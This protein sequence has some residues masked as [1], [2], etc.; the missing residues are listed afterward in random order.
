M[1]EKIF[2]E[3]ISN[4]RNEG[5]YREFVDLTR[6]AADFPYAINNNN[7][8]KILMWCINDY[9][10][11]SSNHQV[12]KAS[13]DAIEKSGIGSG[14]TRNIGGTNSHIV[15]LEKTISALHN[16]EQGL[17]FTSGY[18]AND[19]TLVALSK[20]MPEIVFFSDESNHASI[21]SGIKA[22]GA[23]KYVYNHVDMDS[24]EKGLKKYPLDRPKVI[25]FESVY[26]M[27]GLFS[28]MHEIVELAEKYNALTYV[29]EVHSV[30]MYGKSGAGL[31][32]EFGV[33]NKID[34]IQGTFAKAY[35]TIGGYITGNSDLVDAIRLTAPSFIFTTS[36]PPSIAAAAA[37][38]VKYLQYSDKERIRHQ[39]R[40]ATLK[41]A[42]DKAGIKYYKNY[43]H[44]V[45]IMV[46]DPVLVS[47]ISEKLLRE[48]K[49]YVQHINF[50]TVPKGTERLRITITPAHTDEMIHNLVTA[51]SQVFA[52][53]NLK[54]EEAA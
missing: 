40:V 27:D 44:I 2:E 7:G 36:L 47:K 39:D 42:L 13:K 20:I 10:G 29:D 52:E 51:I 53:V 43:S 50:P 23:E 48:H 26:S 41:K 8:D 4:I 9:L 17:V 25:V 34:I 30:G 32:D 35:G 24:L 37:T 49:M 21:I 6:L 19:A 18:I 45:P 16:K 15:E 12:I 46:N 5:R 31:A 33:S 14:G 54:I 38:S 3:H 22:S 11:M 1:Y 28:P